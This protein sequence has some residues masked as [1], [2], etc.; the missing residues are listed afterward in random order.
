MRVL[1][2]GSSELEHVWYGGQSLSPIICL[3][4][5]CLCCAD[6]CS[7]NAQPKSMWD[8]GSLLDCQPV[9]PL[10]IPTLVLTLPLVWTIV[11]RH[12]ELYIIHPRATQMLE[13]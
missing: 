2:G 10:V 1:A 9:F 12:I 11:D 8:T 6:S 4:A 13:K 5:K 3:I 7:L